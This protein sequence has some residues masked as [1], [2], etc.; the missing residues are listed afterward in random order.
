MKIELHAHTDESSGCAH[1]PAREVV[2]RCKDSGYD[3]IVITDHFSRYL[4]DNC[5]KTAKNDIVDAYLRG[6][7]AARDEGE[8]IGFKVFFGMELLCSS[9]MFND[10]LI[11]G[12]SEEFLY[13]VPLLYRMTLDEVLKLLPSNALV[14]QAH[15]FR[16][17]MTVT[18]PRKIFGIEVHNGCVRHDSRNDIAEMWAEKYSLHKISG[19]DYHQDVDVFC[20]GA[21]FFD[22]I[23]NEAELSEAL[24]ND[25]YTLI[26]G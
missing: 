10:Y 20:C 14:Y 4:L 17:H 22:E 25:R 18:P 26:K 1:V 6:Y 21:D 19:T 8:R 5:G 12:L 24:R 11:Y 3:G 2:R 9:P 7:R 16:N 15:P 23:N 13:T